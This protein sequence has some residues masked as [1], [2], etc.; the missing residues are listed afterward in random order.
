[1]AGILRELTLLQEQEGWLPED[2]LREIAQRLGLPPHRVESVS[3]FYSHFRRTP[4]SGMEVYYRAL[5]PSGEGVWHMT[6]AALHDR[7]CQSP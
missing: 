5:S 2:R 1:M 3:T 4:P 7:R 6:V